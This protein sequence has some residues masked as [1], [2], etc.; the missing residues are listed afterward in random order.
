MHSSAIRACDA[1]HLTDL[2][3]Q[4]LPPPEQAQRTA[5]PLFPETSAS[6]IIFSL[7][8]PL[9]DHHCPAVQPRPDLA[10]PSSYG[11]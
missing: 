4:A 6:L 11:A 3:G 5:L 1:R 8:G 9:N 7:D 2:Q 10:K